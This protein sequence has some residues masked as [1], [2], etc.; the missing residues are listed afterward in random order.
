MSE[1]QNKPLVIKVASRSIPNGT[2]GKW[3]DISG[4]METF[5]KDI[6][7]P[8]FD[9]DGGK[10]SQIVSGM[11]S[12]FSRANL[13]KLS[14]E[15]ITDANEKGEGLLKFYESLI[16]EWRGLIA[17]IALDSKN[18]S[19]E[20]ITLSYS[21]GN[22]IEST[23]NIYEPKGAF[24]NML[25]DRKALWML[26]DESDNS[27]NYPFINV[28]SYKGE[29]IGATS[30]ESVVFTSVKY[31]L[32]ED[33]PWLNVKNNRLCDPLKS[34]ITPDELKELYGY[35]TFLAGNINSFSNYYSNLPVKLQPNTSSLNGAFSRWKKS[36]EV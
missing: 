2:E 8:E 5:T 17:C 11:P 16:D 29:V 23:E 34:N 22:D 6:I 35:V 4:S 25:F 33:R 32:S 18:I 28:I 19:V 15:Y 24:G 10:I 26:Q 9:I 31:N 7:V 20:R 12:V 1:K 21:D 27:K 13:F 36:I 3:N 14:L 30:P